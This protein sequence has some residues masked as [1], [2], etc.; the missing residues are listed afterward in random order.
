[1]AKTLDLITKKVKSKPK[2]I[3]NRI[4]FQRRFL[5][6][7]GFILTDEKYEELLEKTKKDGLFRHRTKTNNSVYRVEYL[8]MRLLVVYDPFNQSL[9]TILT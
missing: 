5:E 3:C 8:D 6:R 9:I 4:H 1:M 7:V 2:K